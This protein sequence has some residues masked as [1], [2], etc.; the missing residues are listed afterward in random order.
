MKTIRFTSVVLATS[1]LCSAELIAQSGKLTNL[2]S[3]QE[4]RAM[5]LDNL[6]GEQQDLL[7]QWILQRSGSVAD[8][9]P[10]AIPSPTVTEAQG[11]AAN[12]PREASTSAQA[13]AQSGTSAA[14]A[15]SQPTATYQDFGKARPL[16]DDMRSR[17]LGKF[18]GWSGDTRFKLENGQVW[19]QRYKTTWRTEMDSPEVVITRHLLG[20]HRME[21]VGTGQSVPVKRVK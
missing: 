20:L 4:M 10:E 5:G 8:A 17:I 3:D 11:V 2:M 6:S 7:L 15:S 16:P 21:V 9:E 18:E 1:L 19:Q 13:V 14:T 12:E